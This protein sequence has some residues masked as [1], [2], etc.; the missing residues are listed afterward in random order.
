MI[1]NDSAPMLHLRANAMIRK[2]CLHLGIQ[3]YQA[4]NEFDFVSKGYKTVTF[5][6]VTD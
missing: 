4:C 6:S 2:F 5:C 1:P 3:T